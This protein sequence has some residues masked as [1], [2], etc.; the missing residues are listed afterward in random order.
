MCC[1]VFPGREQTERQ[2]A[3][4]TSSPNEAFSLLKRI[5]ECYSKVILVLNTGGIVDLGFTEEIP[6]IK[7][8]L[9]FGQAGQ[10][11]GDAL[12]DV[13]SGDVTPSGKLTDTWA[14][15]YEDYPTAR[16]P[17]K[18]ENKRQVEYQE[19]YVGYR[20]FSTFDIPVRYTFGYGLSYTDFSVKALNIALS[21]EE[22]DPQLT[23]TA[24]VKNSGQQYVGKEVVQVYVSSPQGR[25]AKEF[26]RLAGFVKTKELAPGEAQVITLSF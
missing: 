15:S 1:R 4:I 13:I 20:Y 22:G 16:F 12:A 6:S 14:Y 3:A 24:E 26:R 5:G 7:A 9:Q 10:E 21:G 23:V 8:I 18:S 17:N 2:H 11:G 25:L 19:N